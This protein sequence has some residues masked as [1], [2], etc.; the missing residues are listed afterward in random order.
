M[1]PSERRDLIV[2]V[3]EVRGRCPIHRVGDRFH[4]Q[5]GYRLMAEGPIC[6]HALQSLAPYYVPLSRGINPADLGLN[7]PDGAAYVQC[8]D[9]VGY[10]GGG[11]I[12]FRIETTEARRTQ[13]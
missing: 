3:V 13:S 4:V 12:V 11:T 9:P 10:T 7:G 8:L 1:K 5:D 2:E 6:L